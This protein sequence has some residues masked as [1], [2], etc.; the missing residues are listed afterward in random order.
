MP[1]THACLQA[2]T[3]EPT[4]TCIVHVA[5]HTHTHAHVMTKLVHVMT[6]VVYYKNN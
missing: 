2:H 4:G 3:Y 1:N 5:T 6:K